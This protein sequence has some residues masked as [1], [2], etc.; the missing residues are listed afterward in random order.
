M[1]SHIYVCQ[2]APAGNVNT[3]AYFKA[4]VLPLKTASG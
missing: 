2:Y 4:N 3:P 1:N